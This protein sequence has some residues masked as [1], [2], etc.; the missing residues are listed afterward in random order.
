MRELRAQVTLPREPEAPGLSQG[1]S[2]ERSPELPAQRCS[3][4]THTLQEYVSLPGANNN[5]IFYRPLT[6]APQ[7]LLYSWALGLRRKHI[8]SCK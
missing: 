2:L 5:P 6:G 3:T 8:Y 1:Q 4:H 7:S